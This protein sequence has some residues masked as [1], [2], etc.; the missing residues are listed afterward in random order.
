MTTGAIGASVLE[1]HRN[2]NNAELRSWQ[3]LHPPP[4][5]R[6]LEPLRPALPSLLR[7]LTP[8][9]RLLLLQPTCDHSLAVDLALSL[10]SAEPCRCQ[11]TGSFGS[12]SSSGAAA[13]CENCLAATLIVPDITEGDCCTF[14]P[15]CRRQDSADGGGGGSAGL[16]AS[17]LD[18]TQQRREASFQ[19]RRQEALQRI[20]V[21][22]VASLQDVWEY[23]L[24]LPGLP[25][26][27]HAV[28]GIIL[29]GLDQLVGI[30]GG[31]Q[32]AAAATIRMT[33]TGTNRQAT[34]NRIHY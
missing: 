1:Q 4:P 28:G 17:P 10:A 24:Q 19:T 20:Q 7:A 27:Q 16:L 12:S 29:A 14:P 22:H 23:L 3:Q 33:Q 15:L 2:S 13:G 21:R 34:S 30:G 5:T 6:L 18:L 25:M 8:S 32:D 26:E 9:Q 11:R 31:T